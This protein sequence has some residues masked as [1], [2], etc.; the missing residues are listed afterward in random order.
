MING[1]KSK[2]AEPVS[3]PGTTSE[4]VKDIELQQEDEEQGA[5]CGPISRITA[6]QIAYVV[7]ALG[8]LGLIY[9]DYYVSVVKGKQQFSTLQYAMYFLCIPFLFP[10]SKKTIDIIKSKAQPKKVSPKEGKV[11][12]KRVRYYFLDVIK[13]WLTILVV[14]VHVEQFTVMN[15]WFSA[16]WPKINLN[17]DNPNG[18]LSFS[19]YDITEFPPT[20]MPNK[21]SGTSYVEMIWTQSYFMPMFFLISGLNVP[22]S[23]ERKGTFMFMK[24]KI[25]RL[26]VPSLCIYF[27]V[28]P[29]YS[30]TLYAYT[31]SEGTPDYSTSLVVTW[32]LIFLTINCIAYALLHDVIKLIKLPLPSFWIAC[33]TGAFISL[34]E[35]L[36][37]YGD[38]EEGMSLAYIYTGGMGSTIFGAP[39]PVL[40]GA[41]LFDISF[42]FIGCIAGLNGWIAELKEKSTKP[43]FYIPIF[44]ATGICVI[45][46]SVFYF[47]YLS[48]LLVLLRIGQN[49]SFPSNTEAFFWTWWFKT[50]TTV[51]ISFALLVVAIK[52]FDFNSRIL[53]F[54]SLS[55]YGVYLVHWFLI[56]WWL[57]A[58]VAMTEGI[59]GDFENALN[60]A[61]YTQEGYD[62]MRLTCKTLVICAFFFVFVMVML[63]A[64]PLM[65]YVRQ[66]PG[67]RKCL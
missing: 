19:V 58:F 46:V 60:P 62:E 5:S 44:V 33:L 67:F 53:S 21:V 65:Y 63:T 26:M 3:S 20:M 1:E 27:I 41:W 64:W 7:G 51:P 66:L 8:F 22:K 24:D 42:F 31:G 37:V 47:L 17:L 16:V 40:V 15:M 25:M 9:Y 32:Y 54:M 55:A 38:A 12:A 49:K 59:W 11:K 36:S 13:V 18:T 43:S 4:R 45:S 34:L 48:D 14:Y 10:L 39:Q 30:L 61:I 56:C 57:M 52:Y 23:L 6:W 28:N 29:L 2:G 50:F 35:V